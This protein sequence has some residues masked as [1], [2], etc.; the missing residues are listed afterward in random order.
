MRRSRSIA[1][2]GKT[3]GKYFWE[4]FWVLCGGGYVC[5]F[6]LVFTGFFD[7]MSICIV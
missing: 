4:L 1:V 6:F 7:G 3:K 5:G 2:G